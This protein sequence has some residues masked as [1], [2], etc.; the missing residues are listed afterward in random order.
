MKT[1]R[2]LTFAFVRDSGGVLH[3]LSGGSLADRG[4]LSMIGRVHLDHDRDVPPDESWES[5]PQPH[6]WRCAT[7]TAG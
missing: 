1:I 4:R 6:E 2:E 7:A 5:G 3:P